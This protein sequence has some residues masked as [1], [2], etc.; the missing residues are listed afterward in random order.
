M[1]YNHLQGLKSLYPRLSRKWRRWRLEHTSATYL[2][3]ADNHNG[4][5]PAEVSG[6]RYPQ[7]PSR[8]PCYSDP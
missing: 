5:L 1:N 7:T 3:G 2:F 6:V 8:S 4:L